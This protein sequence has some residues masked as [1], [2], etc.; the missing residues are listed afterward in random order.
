MEELEMIKIARKTQSELEYSIKIIEIESK[1]EN[2]EA[3][4][5]LLEFVF[6][7]IFLLAVMLIRGYWKL[8][9]PFAFYS[10]YKL[11]KKY[12]SFGDLVIKLSDLRKKHEIITDLINKAIENNKKTKSRFE[13]RQ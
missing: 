7:L 5:L 11:N 4:A 12:S 3:D 2:F 6:W 9:L 13:K 1:K 8:V 10:Y